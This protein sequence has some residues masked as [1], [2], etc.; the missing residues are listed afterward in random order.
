MTIKEQLLAQKKLILNGGQ[1]D[2]N[3]FK[4]RSLFKKYY[5][6][7]EAESNYKLLLDRWK[8]NHGNYGT[9]DSLNKRQRV[10]GLLD[11]FI[12]DI[13]DEIPITQKSKV[14]PNQMK[15]F[16][17][18]SSKDAEYGNILVELLRSLGLKENEIIFTSN[19]AYG[20]PVGQ[21]IFNWLKSQIAERPFVIY[22]L[23]ENYYK[24]VACLNEMGAA[25]MIENE[26]AAIFT[27]EFD[28]S[29]KEFQ[30]GALDPREIG[31]YINN[32]DRLLSFINLLSANFE[33][34]KNSPLVLQAVKKFLNG[35]KGIN[36]IKSPSKPKIEQQK[37]IPENKT[38]EIET[39]I[40]KNESNTRPLIADNLYSKF[41]GLIEADKLKADEILLLHY[42]I[43]T[44][45]FKL[46]TG[47]QQEEENSNIKEWEEINDIKPVLSKSYE[48]VLRRFELR[49]FTEV[50][51]VT[52]HG[53]PKEVKLKE[54]LSK[55]ILDL[56][57]KTQS[58]IKKV[59]EDNF[60]DHSTDEVVNEDN[61]L[62]F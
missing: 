29:S 30:N 1:V 8:D 57:E 6:K 39:S 53:N 56:P 20:I 45:R 25:W 32:E 27:P 28:L 18:H 40:K 54:E 50:S 26:H 5:L 33:I 51:Q 59:V 14:K 23:S 17:T 10:A 38:T 15:I 52:S 34:S 21:N 43:D 49:G 13:A 58:K 41:L 44:S 42:L 3:L 12:E 19:V 11:V 22:L 31:F 36:T 62:P 4:V 37:V 24:S 2:V 60:H 9:H 35:I 47:W 46:L 7:E 16:I 61:D 48:G 55:H